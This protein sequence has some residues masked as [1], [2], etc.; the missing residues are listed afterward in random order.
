MPAGQT[1]SRLTSYLADCG[2]ESVTLPF[3]E[4]ERILGRKLPKSAYTYQVWWKPSGGHTHCQSWIKARYTAAQVSLFDKKVIFKKQGGTPPLR[5]KP[6]LGKSL[7]VSNVQQKHREPITFCGYKFIFVQ[8]LCPEWGLNGAIKKFHPQDQYDNLRKLSLLP[9]GNGA[10]CRF[11][12]EADEVPG[13]YLWVLDGKVI[14]IGETSQ[15]RRRFN[16]GYGNISPRNCYLGGQSTNCR[17]NKVV[18]ELFEIG[19]II[20]L[21]FYETYDHKRMELELLNKVRTKYNL[22]DN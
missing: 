6:T 15:L 14:Y 16:M 7:I 19:K 22:K 10:F 8:Q 1:Y 20:D 21:Y 13:V 3:S 2:A 12:I 9:D 4:I 11:S 18:M 17:M 5:M